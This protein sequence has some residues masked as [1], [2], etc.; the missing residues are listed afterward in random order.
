MRNNG[1][2]TTLRLAAVGAGAAALLAACGLG[3]GSSSGST[4][5]STPP[6]AFK[7]IPISTTVAPTTTVAGSGG[8]GNSGSGDS[9]GTYT[10]KAGDYPLGVAKK[11]GVTLQAL[12]DANGGTLNLVPGQKL[13]IPT[14]SGSSSSTTSSGSSGSTAASTTTTFPPDQPGQYTVRPNDGWS[15]IASKLGVD[16]NTLAAFNDMT[17]KTVLTPGMKLKIPPATTTTTKA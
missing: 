3:G 17:T 9:G 14:S 11:L 15:I 1:V 10:V 2:R 8:S 5:S 13:K 7:T 4:S 6:T 16:A 12:Q